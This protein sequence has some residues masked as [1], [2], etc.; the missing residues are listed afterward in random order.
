MPVAVS[1]VV[2]T[3]LSAALLL[4]TTRPASAQRGLFGGM[5]GDGIA[6][7]PVRVVVDGG[8]TVPSGEFKATHQNGFHYGAMLILTIPG[9]PIAIRPEVSL[10]SFRVREPPTASTLLTDYKHTKTVSGLGNIE[11]PIAGGLYLM[12]GAGV[13]SLKA[14]TA[15]LGRQLSASNLMLDLGGGIRFKLGE[16]IDGFLEARVGTASFDKEKFGYSRAQ[17]VPLTFG[18]VF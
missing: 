10:T 13:L 15:T 1:S 17:F 7:Q 3:L 9:L 5:G 11:L 4:A 16:R 12:G 18:L 8:L 14:D 6:Q 2:R